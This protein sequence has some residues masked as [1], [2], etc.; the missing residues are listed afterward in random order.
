MNVGFDGVYCT[1]EHNKFTEVQ[2]DHRNLLMG[3][4]KRA[5]DS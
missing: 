3:R 5:L 1:A 4:R 2:G